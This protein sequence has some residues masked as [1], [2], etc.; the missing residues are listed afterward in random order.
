VPWLAE[1]IGRRGRDELV[2]ALEAR[3]VPAARVL[4]VSAALAAMEAAHPDG[5]V[6]AAD[7][8]RL[9]PSALHV[10]RH[11]LPLRRPPPRIGEHTDEILAELGRTA[12]EAND[13]RA[14]GIVR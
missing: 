2:A 13:L 14:K 7:G 6:V 11:R 4:P 1:A 3:D 5:W 9:A 12:A 10:D 8:V